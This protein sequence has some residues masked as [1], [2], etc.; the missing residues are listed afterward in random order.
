MVF[1]GAACG[2][3]VIACA[4]RAPKTSPSSSELLASR[5]APW[6][7]V[8]ATSPAA[9]SRGTEVRA[10]LVGVDAA[11]HVVRRR[12]DRNPI[13]R[14][15]ETDAASTS[16]QSSETVRARSRG[17]RCASVR[18]HRTAGVLRLSRNASRHDVPRREVAVGVMARHE[19]LTSLVDQARPFTAQRF[20]DQ[21][22]RRAREV[23]RRR[24]KLDELEIRDA[25]A[26]VVRE[27]DPVAGRDRGVRRLAKHL[28]GTA[29]RQQCR[30]RVHL[31]AR[32]ARVEVAKRRATWPSS[33][34]RSVTSA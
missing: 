9:N 3:S 12:T 16:R 21:E 14:Q 19:R 4:A 29:G 25:R 34:I 8:Q 6:T 31:A 18:I 2:G 11:H 22:P 17:S 10:P 24:M 28:T 13:A 7:P 5:L 30:A 32:A 23:E 15:V 26:G 1:S 20:G 27:R 33:T